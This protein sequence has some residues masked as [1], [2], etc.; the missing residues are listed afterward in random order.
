MNNSK[1]KNTL[2]RV[3]KTFKFFLISKFKLYISYK[4]I[5][6][7]IFF[8]GFLTI[9]F[10][11]VFSPFNYFFLKVLLLL[12]IFFFFIIGLTSFLKNLL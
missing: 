5:M 11:Y 1:Y 2:K 4:N 10:L 3:K 12:K 8:L 6:F 7:I 9:G